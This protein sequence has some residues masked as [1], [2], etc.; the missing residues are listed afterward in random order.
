MVFARK[1]IGDVLSFPE[2]AGSTIRL[3]DTDEGRLAK[4]TEAAEAMSRTAASQP[5]SSRRP[6]V[7]RCSR[8]RTTSST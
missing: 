1:L 3:M 4:T 6:T 5:I 7:D 2:L 8:T